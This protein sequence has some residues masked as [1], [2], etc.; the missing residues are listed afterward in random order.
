MAELELKSAVRARYGSVAADA[1]SHEGAGVRQ[2]AHSFGYSAEQLASIP[3][4][5]NL[6]LSC[7]NP[8]ALADLRPGETVVD[9]GSGGGLDVFLAARQVG[10]TGRAIGIDMTPEMIA[11]ARGAAQ[12]AG[13][14]N[15]EF[16]LAEIEQ[17]P[18]EPDSVDCVISNC[19][20]NLVPNKARALAEIF[21]VLKPG[22]RVAISDIALK[23]A[24]PPGLQESLAA[25]VGCIGGAIGIEAY[26]ELLAAAG[27]TAIEV[28]DSRADL[29]VYAQLMAADESE[30][31]D[32]AERPVVSATA[33]LPIFTSSCC[34]SPAG[35]ASS[36]VAAP[37][38]LRSELAELVSRFDAN[39][40]AASVKVR[41]IKPG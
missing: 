11:R 28:V 23:Q 10:P 13:L 30:A 9:L 41:A 14:T 6:G 18:L 33:E 31:A 16:H 7:G 15:V 21:R 1:A 12:S 26:R 29:N 17:L 2:V 8:T 20:L 39:E 27:F 22:G 24:L 25:Y 36:T 5:A 40:Y 3:A 4:E 34:G 38:T 19:V 37:R 35:N 32:A